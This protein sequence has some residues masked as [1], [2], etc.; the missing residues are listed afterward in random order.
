MEFRELI[1]KRYSVRA[2][3]PDP[4]EDDKL[5]QVLEAARMAPTACNIQPFRLIVIETAKIKDQLSRVYSGDWLSKAPI[6]ICGCTVPSEAWVRQ[7]D[8]KNHADIDL[9]IAMD[10]L[11]LAAADLGLGTCWIAAF[12]PEAAREVFQIP[13]GLVPTI[14]T[15]LGYP[16][17][18]PRPKS[19]KSIE[20]L[21][22]YFS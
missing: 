20:E 11:I 12:D 4:V 5:K 2:Y 21:V 18:A 9:A 15:P 3:K 10:H 6:V 7:Y 19:R 22:T 8:A 16:A 1:E 13:D 14:L 17:D